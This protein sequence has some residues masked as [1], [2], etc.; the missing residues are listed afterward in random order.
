MSHCK[1][2]TH[3][4]S[5]HLVTASSIQCIPGYSHIY[6]FYSRV[7]SNLSSVDQVRR[8]QSNVEQ[9]SHIQFC[10]KQVSRI[11]PV[12]RWVTLQSSDGNL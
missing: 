12:L 7:D 11:H 2:K 4:S 6:L 9:S 3:L 8:D 5:I 1:T 10:A